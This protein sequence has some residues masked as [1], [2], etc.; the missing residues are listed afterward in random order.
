MAQIEGMQQL[1][2][3]PLVIVHLVFRFDPTLDIHAA[4]AN[5]PVLHRIRPLQHMRLHSFFLRKRQPLLRVTAGG[6][7]QSLRK[8]LTL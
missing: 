2:D 8:S 7:A 6:I 5:Q 3:C 4:P 1:A